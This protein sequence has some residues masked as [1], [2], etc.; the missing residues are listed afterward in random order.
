MDLHPYDTVRH[1]ITCHDNYHA[2]DLIYD[3]RLHAC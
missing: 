1:D 3:S 2:Y